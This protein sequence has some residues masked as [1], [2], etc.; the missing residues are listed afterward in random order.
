MCL[1][2]EMIRVLFVTLVILLLVPINFCRAQLYISEISEGGGT[3]SEFLELYNSG[4]S[5]VDLTGY[6][7]I[8]V[9]SSTDLSEYVFDIN[10]DG[11]G[12]DI[13]IPAGGLWVVSRGADRAT[14]E[15]TFTSFPSVAKYYD[16]NS[17]L[18][19]ASSTARRWRLRA[20]D[21]TANTDDGTLIDDTNGAAGGAGQR[22]IQN[23][24]GTFTTS[25][26][27]TGANSNPGQ[28]DGDQSLPVE[29]TQFGAISRAGKIELSWVTESEINNLGFIIY[30][31]ESGQG[32]QELTSYL[33]DPELAGQGSVTWRTDYQFIDTNVRIGIT[34]TYQLADVDY[35][36]RQTRH[37]PQ[38]VT[39][40][41]AGLSVDSVWPNPANPITNLYFTMDRAN[42]VSIQVIDIGGRLVVKL[43]ENDY[44]AGAHR[45]TWNGQNHF[46][47][48]VSSGIYLMQITSSSMAKNEKVILVR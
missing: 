1:E 46:G 25:T 7:L 9:N 33:T 44:P 8:R 13:D 28:L 32:Y 4:S 30:R 14:F 41:A 36:G 15:S 11:D 45:I 3:D 40:R 10:T 23:P 29:L 2:V 6:K 18:Y 42:R 22:T 31:K 48:P 34:Y 37:H 24:I 5:A 16:G 35:A 20:N 27:T 39:V 26:S 38:T 21:G 19:F 43:A 12:G 17:L 47:Q